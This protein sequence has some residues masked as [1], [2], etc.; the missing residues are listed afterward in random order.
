MK[1]K[2]DTRKYIMG[3]F[4]PPVIADVRVADTCPSLGSGGA[5]IVAGPA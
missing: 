5:E 1:Q 3:C 2:L 4:L